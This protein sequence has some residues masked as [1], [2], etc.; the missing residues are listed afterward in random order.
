MTLDWMKRLKD[1]F[2][3]FQISLPG[4]HNSASFKVFDEDL[5]SIALPWVKCQEL[6]ITEQLAAGIRVFDL[7]GRCIPNDRTR[8]Y[9]EGYLL[10]LTMEQVLQ[11]F[12]IFLIKNPS[13]FLLVRIKPDKASEEFSRD[14]D[15]IHTGYRS[16]L[17]HP[18]HVNVSP[19]VGEARGK[20]IILDNFSSFQHAYTSKYGISYDNHT[21]WNI[22]DRWNIGSPPYLKSKVEKIFENF[23][24]ASKTKHFAINFLSGSGAIVVTPR[25]VAVGSTLKNLR[26]SFYLS[27]LRTL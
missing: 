24:I 26:S 1:H 4:T 17:W 11:Q 5:H 27:I 16:F 7:R 21:A 8:L 2:S 22:Q 12:I 10:T 18:V 13:E 9:H 15:R 25:Y 20:I 23:K 3:V 19:T 6:S 14:M